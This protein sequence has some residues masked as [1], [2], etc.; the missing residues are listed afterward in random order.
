MRLPFLSFLLHH[1]RHNPANPA[2][3]P[4]KNIFSQACFSQ[5]HTL[6][7]QKYKISDMIN[8]ALVYFSSLCNIYNPRFDLHLYSLV[9]CIFLA[10]K[11]L[12]IAHHSIL[13]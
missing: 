10:Y 7:L 11:C 3:Y 8:L 13:T 2:R 12:F 5:K 9:F 4:A 6:P 1:I